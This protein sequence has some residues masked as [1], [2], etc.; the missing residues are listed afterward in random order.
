MLL[1]LSS[2][3]N[4]YQNELCVVATQVRISRNKTL[5]M[6]MKIM[7]MFARNNSDVIEVQYF[8][9][10]GVGEG[11][12]LEFFT[13]VSHE[14]Q[15]RDLHLWRTEELLV[16]VGK[17]DSRIVGGDIGPGENTED[18]VYAPLGLFPR[19]YPTNRVPSSVLKCFRFLG[20]TTAR[21]LLDGRLM[22][23]NINPILFRV[24]RGGPV[25]L[26]DVKLVD[27][28]LGMTLEKLQ[29]AADQAKS[30]KGPAMIDDATVEDLYIAFSLPGKC[31]I[32]G[33]LILQNIG[34]FS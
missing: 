11:P 13:L 20:R 18:Y 3:S 6:A 10:C 1:L 2:L 22:D 21:A 9:E 34:C 12:T 27:R 17:E 25:D 4:N 23:L 33:S 30:T 26:F 31:S 32:Y 14:I 8:N 7:E 16:S 24:I 15:R 19:P 5:P 29:A 28:A